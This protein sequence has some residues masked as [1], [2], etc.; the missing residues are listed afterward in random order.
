MIFELFA[1]SISGAN[2]KK[3][4]SLIIFIL[5]VREFKSTQKDVLLMAVELYMK[6][7]TLAKRFIPNFSN[8]FARF[9]AQIA[10][11]KSG[12]R[13]NSKVSLDNLL[14]VDEQPNSEVFRDNINTWIENT[15]GLCIKKYNNQPNETNR[16]FLFLYRLL[17]IAY[18]IRYPLRGKALNPDV[19]LKIYLEHKICSAL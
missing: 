17:T 6:V 7:R 2:N 3:S 4:N 16:D 18:R 5:N 10:D 12:P 8:I 11:Q 19:D 15:L 9:Q 14:R 1:R 13:M